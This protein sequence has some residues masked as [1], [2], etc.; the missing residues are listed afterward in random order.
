MGTIMVIQSKAKKEVKPNI[1][2]VKLSLFEKAQTAKEVI[3]LI[4]NKRTLAKNFILSKNSVKDGSYEQTNISVKKVTNRYVVYT[5]DN[6]TVSEEV[7]NNFPFEVRSEWQKEFKEDFLFY[8]ASL[9]IGIVLKYGDTVVNDLVNIYNMAIEKEMQCTY[10]YA[11]SEDVLHNTQNDLFIE[12]INKGISDVS[13]IANNINIDNQNV[14]LLEVID[15]DVSNSSKYLMASD[16]AMP[17]R[18]S[19]MPNYEPES[20]MMP[21]LIEDIFDNTLP[22]TR[23]I[24]MKFEI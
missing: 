3:D 14:K 15:T 24:D 5:K 19:S 7:Y 9:S 8:S 6:K 4:N 16:M 17:M 18:K 10:D 20:L 1:V 13:Y 21:E 11:I 2:N 23:S 22:I 12:C